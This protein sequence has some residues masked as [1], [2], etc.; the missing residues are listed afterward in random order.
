MAH[1]MG[2][3]AGVVALQQAWQAAADGLSVEQAA[4]K[5]TEFAESVKQFGGKK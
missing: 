1:P 4:A 3:A 5:Y 2:A